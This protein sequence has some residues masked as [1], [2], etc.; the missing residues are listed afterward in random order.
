MSTTYRV[1]IIGTTG[2]APETAAVRLIASL[3]RH[4][5]AV[6][7]GCTRNTATLALTAPMSLSPAEMANAVNAALSTPALLGWIRDGTA[8]QFLDGE[9]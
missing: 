6:L 2:A 1:Q 8:S 4:W 9:S 3:P 5:G 7:L